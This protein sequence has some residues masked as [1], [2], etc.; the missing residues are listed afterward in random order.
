MG[1]QY[2]KPTFF[3]RFPQNRKTP[4]N[5]DVST[6][7]SVLPL[8][9][10]TRYYLQLVPLKVYKDNMVCVIFSENLVELNNYN[11]IKNHPHNHYKMR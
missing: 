1:K 7:V 11:T 3:T 9:K 6:F 2:Q 8:L 5:I 4:I 10:L